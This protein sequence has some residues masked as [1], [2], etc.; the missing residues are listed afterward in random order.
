LTFGYNETEI[1]NAQNVPLI[2]D[3][4]KPEGG[5]REGYPVN[6]L[7]SI[8][9]M[10]LTTTRDSQFVDEKECEP[11]VFLQD[12]KIDYLVYEGP[13]DPPLQVGFPIHLII[14][15]FTKCFI[16]Y[17]AGNKIRLYPAFRRLM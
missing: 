17:Q 16:T 3:L 4:V 5:N 7:F 10:D 14:K 12:D 11:G 8:D 13:V 1:T 2:F 9:S 15:T 6:S